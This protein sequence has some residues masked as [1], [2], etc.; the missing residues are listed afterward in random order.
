MPAL[1]TGIIPSQNFEL[2]RDRIGQILSLEIGNQYT[3]TGNEDLNA[4]VYNDRIVPYDK[5]DCPAINVSFVSSNYTSKF[6]NSVD[7][8]NIYNIDVYCL[9]PSTATDTADKLANIRLHKLLGICRTILSDPQYRTLLFTAP[10]MA[11]VSV[12]DIKIAAPEAMQD[13]SAIVMGRLT[14]MVNCPETVQLLDAP[15]VASHLTSIK[16]SDSD[17]GYYWEYQA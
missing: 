6:V 7:G 16:L 10:S 1:I 4:T 8:S 14:F 17:K 13:S 9:A 5:T 15:L 2:V 12:R 3:L 11:H